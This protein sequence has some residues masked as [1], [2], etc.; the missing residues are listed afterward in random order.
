MKR[1]QT[2]VVSFLIITNVTHPKKVLIVGSGGREHALC[3]KMAQSP[4]VD[5]I[6][7]APGNA[8]TAQCNK[9]ENIN[10]AADDIHALLTFAQKQM[11]DLTLV[12]PEIPLAHGIVDQFAQHNL[13]CFGPNKQAVQME[14]SKKFAKDFMHRHNIPTAAYQSFTNAQNAC[15]Y[16][17]QQSIFPIVIKA[18]GLAA[19]KG[20]VIAQDQQEAVDAIET[21]MQKR[22]FGDAGNTIVIE[23]FLHGREVSFFALCDGITVLPLTTAQ[24][25]KKLLDDNKGPNTGGMGAICPAHID[26]VLQQRIMHEIIKPTIDGLAKEGICYTGI[27][28]AGLMISPEGDPYVLEFN[29]RL[30]D[31]ETQPIMMRLKNDLFDLCNGVTKQTLSNCVI[32]CD[33]RW[34]V[35]LVLASGGYPTAYKKGFAISGLQHRSKHN[36]TVVFHAGTKM[37]NNG[38]V[39]HGGRVLCV[40]AMGNDIADARQK[41]YTA[42]SKIDWKGKYCRSDIGLF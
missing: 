33:E 17:K 2:I 38:V 29:C 30:G 25:Y 6:F 27:L 19:G 39:T 26:D 41:V 3:W 11:I 16:I 10:I 24:D 5:T 18:D 12:G 15:D 7:V 21:M 23:Q 37:Q 28:Y 14:S 32:E 42:A 36:E 4:K 1:I 22:Q 8:G 13:A 20:V 9:T 35:G 34:A 40:T 31:P